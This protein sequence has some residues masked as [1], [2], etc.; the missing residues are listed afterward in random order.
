MLADRSFLLALEVSES[1][2]K[3]LSKPAQRTWTPC[4]QR[5]LPCVNGTWIV[6]MV[7]R[8]PSVQW[9]VGDLQINTAIWASPSLVLQNPISMPKRQFAYMLLVNQS[10]ADSFMQYHKTRDRE[11]FANSQHLPPAS[12]SPVHSRLLAP[13]SHGASCNSCG[14]RSQQ[15]RHRQPRPSPRGRY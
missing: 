6:T 2:A 7:D 10:S 11:A 1:Y 5:E 15:A 4:S 8:F 14:Q 9:H 12:E 3:L 13:A